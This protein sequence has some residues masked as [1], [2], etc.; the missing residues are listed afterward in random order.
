MMSGAF[1]DV[2]QDLQGLRRQFAAE[3]FLS[4]DQVNGL[5]RVHVQTAA[6]TATVFLQG[7]HLTAWQPAGEQPVI[8]LSRKSAL[9]PGKALR[10]G[11]PVVFPWFSQDKKQD[12][13]DGHPGPM[14]GFARIQPWSLERAVKQG[15]DVELVFALGPTAMSKALG[16]DHF[17]LRLRFVFGKTLREELTVRNE[18]AQPL[19]F[20]DD[21][22]AYFQTKD[23]HETT[24]SGLEDVGFIDK[25]DAFKLKPAQHH[26]ITFTGKT[27]RVYLDTEGPCRVHDGAGRRTLLLR[28]EGSRTTVVWNP[29]GAM[30]DL[31]E[32]EWPGMVAVETANVDADS[33]KLAPGAEHRMA[34]HV[35]V[36]RDQA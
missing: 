23:I 17:Q 7:A 21:F 15:D 4:F 14:H 8:F 10:G 32:D 31:G 26:P 12:R 28:K 30:P 25:V 9:E 29:A 33:V 27:D 1:V 36:Q 19:E 34:M 16:F 20:E 35:E 11:V 22:H 13:I 3:K 2:E 5:V 18:G 24:V 6:A